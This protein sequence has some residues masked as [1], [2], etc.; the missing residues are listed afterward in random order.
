VQEVTPIINPKLNTFGYVA[1]ND[2]DNE[3]VVVFRGT[4]MSSI[5]NWM[6]DLN[7]NME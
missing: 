5:L 4:Q 7:I 1:Y 2:K 6:S 3:V